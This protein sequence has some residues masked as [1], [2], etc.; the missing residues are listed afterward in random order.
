MMC[1]PTY[2]SWLR[3]DP[4]SSNSK[5]TK[6]SKLGITAIALDQWLKKYGK[7]GAKA[8]ITA[9]HKSKTVQKTAKVKSVAES[10]K[11][12][13]KTTNPES[14]SKEIKN[15]EISLSFGGGI[16][17]YIGTITKEAAKRLNGNLSSDWLEVMKVLYDDVELILDD[18]WGNIAVVDKEGTTLETYG[19]VDELLPQDIFQNRTYEANANF[20]IDIDGK[21]INKDDI[22]EEIFTIKEIMNQEWGGS[23]RPNWK[24]MRKNDYYLYSWIHVHGGCGHIDIKYQGEFD[25]SKLTWVYLKLDVENGISRLIGAKYSGKIFVFN[26][27]DDNGADYMTPQIIYP[28]GS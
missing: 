10:G 20:E 15:K 13:Q 28:K 5:L 11:K 25:I 1:R 16:E 17:E 9:E 18:S 21:E 27:D 19:R 12:R 23:W 26:M 7:S 22:D 6:A 2:R 8:P 24:P 3:P 14:E 4:A